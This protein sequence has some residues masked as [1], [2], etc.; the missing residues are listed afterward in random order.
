MSDKKEFYIGYLPKAPKGISRFTAVAILIFFLLLVASAYV[1]V[2]NQTTIN[3]GLR[4][5]Q[6]TITTKRLRLVFNVSL[7]LFI[8]G[9]T[10]VETG[11]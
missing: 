4:Y 6:T 7:N 11:I 10:A 8:T 3:N 1:V 2:S 9:Q 5:G